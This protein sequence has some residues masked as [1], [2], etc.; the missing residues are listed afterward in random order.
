MSTDDE[1]EA[2]LAKIAKGDRRALRGLYDVTSPRLYGLCWG[3]LR[4]DDRAQDVLISVYDGIWRSAGYVRANGSS[5]WVWLL[6]LARDAAV[7]RLRLDTT[8]GHDNRAPGIARRLY[9]EP[10]HQQDRQT[11]VYSGQLAACLAELPSDHA[12]VLRS[13]YLEGLSY[14]DLADQADGDAQALR[15]EMRR[16]LD[17]LRACLSR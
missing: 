8:N 1:L 9:E 11:S 15:R 7:A 3:I 5:P 2:M 14:S 17:H 6:S 12:S 13:V 10:D 16:S 4:D